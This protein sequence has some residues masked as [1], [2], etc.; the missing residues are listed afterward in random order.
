MSNQNAFQ[1]ID[2]SRL[3]R[4]AEGLTQ[5]RPLVV[6]FITFV[7][8]ALV[9]ALGGFLVGK[10]DNSFGQS[11]VSLLTAI[12]LF[13]VLCTGLSAVGVMLMDRAKSIPVRSIT[14]AFV[15]GL[16]C[17]PKFIGFALFL[18]ALL[19]VIA[20]A[21]ALVYFICKI[22]GIGPLLLFVAHPVLVIA[23]TLIFAAVAWVGIPLFAPAVWEGRS[24]KEALSLL[25]AASKNRFVTVVALLFVVYLVLSIITGLVLGALFPGY[26]FMTGLAATILGQEAF[27]GG[28]GS[29]MNLVLP[30][31]GAGVS[32]YGGYG[33]GASSGSGYMYAGLMASA[34]IFGIVISLLAQ[35]LIMG[36]NL[37]YLISTDGLDVSASQS[38]I[39]ARLEQMR[40]K[41]QE[42]QERAR[43]AAERARQGQQAPA[44]PTS[45]SQSAVSPNTTAPIAAPEHIGPM[46]CPNCK[47]SITTEDVF[48]VECGHKLKG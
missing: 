48:C 10:L 3:L 26:T 17:L 27:S 20:V 14:D 4:A 37:V 18:L 33:D 36:I 11:A 30:G 45:A 22:P 9:G 35:V 1:Q 6:G 16:M 28:W 32:N 44:A 31:G 5:W 13:V 41:A 42:A 12:C 34:L 25:H 21:A 23:A 40:K 7:A 15:F 38:E 47:S 19:L 2:F 39:E 46:L 43:Q 29:V 24:F 8:V